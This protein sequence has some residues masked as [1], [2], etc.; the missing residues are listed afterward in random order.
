MSKNNLW[1]VNEA[2]S[3][4]KIILRENTDNAGRKT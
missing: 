1:K 4:F 2:V 3:K